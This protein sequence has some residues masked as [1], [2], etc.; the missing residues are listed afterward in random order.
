MSLGRGRRI[1]LGSL[2]AAGVVAVTAALPA[3]TEWLAGD[4][5]TQSAGVT[6]DFRVE[7]L[8]RIDQLKTAFNEDVGKV[9]IYLLL[10]PT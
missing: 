7:G 4:T 10:S 3:L 6:A 5:D 8:A 1:L 2:I 9:R